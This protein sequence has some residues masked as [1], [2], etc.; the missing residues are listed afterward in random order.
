MT[1]NQ[2]K[3]TTTNLFTP[4]MLSLTIINPT[5]TS[6]T[7]KYSAKSKNFFLTPRTGTPTTYIRTT[8]TETISTPKNLRHAVYHT[9]F[10]HLLHN[11]Y[12]H[13]QLRRTDTFYYH[14]INIRIRYQYRSASLP[15]TIH[16]P[17]V[18]HT[19]YQYPR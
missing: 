19:R 16:T 10:T 14:S 18:L 11:F 17:Y 7:Y 1:I 15:T 5:E 13:T 12:V 9:L 3:H 6:D 8:R 4:S 2:K